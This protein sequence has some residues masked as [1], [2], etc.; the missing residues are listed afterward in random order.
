MYKRQILYSPSITPKAAVRQLNRWIA[1]KPGLL[2]QL[3]ATGMLPNAKCY[4]PIQVHAKTIHIEAKTMI[5]MTAKQIVPAVIAYATRLAQSI[6]AVRAVSAGLDTS[7]QEELLARVSALL[8]QT[9]DALALLEKNTNAASLAK[10]GRAQAVAFRDGVCLS[11]I[12]I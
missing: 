10:E 6:A 8:R 7:V 2:E 4:T 11:L 5:D 1:F 3:A 12:H 9:Q